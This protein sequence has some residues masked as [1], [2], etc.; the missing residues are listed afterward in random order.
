MII[1]R[2]GEEI[3]TLNM[4][5]NHLYTYI[6]CEHMLY[7][8]EVNFDLE[9]IK[10]FLN[11]LKIFSEEKE[12]LVNHIE[13]DRMKKCPIEKA[14]Y[15]KI[16]GCEFKQSD[17]IESKSLLKNPTLKKVYLNWLEYPNIY[18]DIKKLIEFKCKKDIGLEKSIDLSYYLNELKKYD[19]ADEFLDILKLEIS[20]SI[21]KDKIE[22][23]INYYNNGFVNIN[24]Q[25]ENIQKYIEY[26][27]RN[28]NL[29]KVIDKKR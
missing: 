9:E 14:P 6:L 12:D 20:L 4:D 25:I 24:K 19:I 7:K 26:G 1:H 11:R 28:N 22:N 18:H 8:V 21:P 5:N 29:I 10:N 3:D 13:Y 17:I 16:L 23:L 15:D 27:A 2:L